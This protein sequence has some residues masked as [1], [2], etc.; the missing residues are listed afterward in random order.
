MTWRKVEDEM[1]V[2]FLWVIVY[3]GINSFLA[4]R[5]P[6]EDDDAEWIDSDGE[7]ADGITH[8]QPFPEPPLPAAPADDSQ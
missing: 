3:D 7:P 1:P 6:D 8:W 4:K 2:P 5:Y